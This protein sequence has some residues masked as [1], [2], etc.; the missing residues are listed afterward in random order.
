MEVNIHEAK[1]QLSR[2]IERVLTGE[3]VVIAKRGVPVAVLTR[4]RGQSGGRKLGSA[5]GTVEFLPG[6][7]EPMT[8]KELD[9]FL[10]R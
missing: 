8:A 2:L 4:V 3:R 7:N 10:G 5:V 9:Q 1:T 6:W